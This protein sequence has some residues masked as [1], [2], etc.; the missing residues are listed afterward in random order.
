MPYNLKDKIFYQMVERLEREININI[1]ELISL[2]YRTTKCGLSFT[3]I[4][5]MRHDLKAHQSLL[6]FSLLDYKISH[7]DKINIVKRYV[8][9]DDRLFKIYNENKEKDFKFIVNGS[10]VEL[11]PLE[12]K[13]NEKR[14]TIFFKK[15][16]KIKCPEFEP[17]M[18]IAENSEAPRMNFENIK[19]VQEEIKIEPINYNVN[20]CG[21]YNKFIDL[22][23]TNKHIIEEKLNE[24]NYTKEEVI[25]V[26]KK[27]GSS[28]YAERFAPADCGQILR[29]CEG[30]TY[31]AYEPQFA[32]EIEDERRIF[33][34]AE[35]FNLK[36]FAMFS[37][38]VHELLNRPVKFFCDIDDKKNTIPDFKNY[39][40]RLICSFR[41]FFPAYFK[42]SGV[43]NIDH[44]IAIGQDYNSAHIIFNIYD[45]MDNRFLTDS[46]EKQKLFWREFKK[47][48]ADEY[49]DLLVY[50]RNA[51]LRIPLCPKFDGQSILYPCDN[52]IK[53]YFVGTFARSGDYFLE[54]VPVKF[55]NRYYTHYEISE[56]INILNNSSISIN[57]RFVWMEAV[58]RIFCFFHFLKYEERVERVLTFCQNKLWDTEKDNLEN[59]E[60]CAIY[61]NYKCCYSVDSMR[62]FFK[63]HEANKKMVE[64][65]NYDDYNERITV[66]KSGTNTG[67]TYKFIKKYIDKKVL[68]ISYRRSLAAEI[69]SQ[70]LHHGAVSVSKYN[71]VNVDESADHFIV[72][73]ESLA[74]FPDIS[75]FDVVF[76]DEIEELI[77]QFNHAFMTQAST[78]HI[79]EGIFKQILLEKR[80]FC[81][82]ANIGTRTFNFL[83][84]Y[85]LKFEY[86]ENIKKD[87]ADYTFVEY[88]QGEALI[89]EIL[90]LAESGHKLAIA[91]N[92]LKKAVKM[93]AEIKHL[94]AQLNKYGKT[95]ILCSKTDFVEPEQWVNYDFVIYTPTIESG[96]NFLPVYFDYIIGYFQPNANTYTSCYQQLFRV[97]NPKNKKILIH[98]RRGPGEVGKKHIDYLNKKHIKL[99]NL[100]AS[101]YTITKFS[102]EAHKTIINNRLFGTYSNIYF[103]RLF[104]R[105]LKHA[106]MKC[107]K[108]IKDIILGGIDDERI[109]TNQFIISQLDVNNENNKRLSGQLA[110]IEYDTQVFENYNGNM[111]K[112]ITSL[113]NYKMINSQRNLCHKD[114][115]IRDFIKNYTYFGEEMRKLICDQDLFN[116]FISFTNR[117]VKPEAFQKRTEHNQK[118][119]V[120]SVLLNYG[121]IVNIHGMLEFAYTELEKL[122]EEIK[123]NK[124]VTTPN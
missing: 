53:E 54:P 83:N 13:K 66:I 99:Q 3:E 44:H 15:F 28:I 116:I 59:R 80:V 6:R 97:R 9:N 95:L 115:R 86:I 36:Y 55:T 47:F 113:C 40:G 76:L 82:S 70:V 60:L 39:L 26:I 120:N 46:P 37:P 121:Y 45:D 43:C 89:N 38:T 21:D 64:E 35:D 20:R 12:T 96:V 30:R 24:L 88:E 100:I 75:R 69:K 18:E 102:T 57:K 17:V 81:V 119:L 68:Y 10:F 74:R 92:S 52:K 62:D 123:K 104:L 105:E 87:K 108:I 118:Q 34:S 106:G 107:E 42:I 101:N 90:K 61:K 117:P 112:V 124:W 27:Y 67:K 72:Q 19:V 51:Q 41:A 1:D 49:I 109:L 2:F 93:S 50:R 91:T 48:I 29:V 63:P 71:D 85:G 56:F 114:S 103:R 78:F 22:I 16:K 77:A 7:D 111:E 110:Y 65:L 32:V 14:Q 73:L 58:R 33:I 98:I 11:M 31:R 5:S 8:T 84:R 25:Q 79:L 4:Y 122:N 94:A 23:D